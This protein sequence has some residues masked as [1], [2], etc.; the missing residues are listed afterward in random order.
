[1]TTNLT[2]RKLN[3]GSRDGNGILLAE[4]GKTRYCIGVHSEMLPGIAS[5][6]TSHLRFHDDEIYETKILEIQGWDEPLAEFTAKA[7]QAAETH[8]AGRA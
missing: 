6:Q 8:A 7:M 3:A 1:M 5:G 4:H 2:W